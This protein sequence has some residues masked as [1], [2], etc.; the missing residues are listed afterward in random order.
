MPD[1]LTTTKTLVVIKS[2]LR[3]D[4]ALTEQAEAAGW[5]LQLFNN[6]E[7]AD[8]FLRAEEQLGEINLALF[9]TPAEVDAAVSLLKERVIPN[10]ARFHRILVAAQLAQGNFAPLE[11]TVG[12][13]EAASERGTTST[14]T[15]GP[16]HL[17]R[18]IAAVKE[19]LT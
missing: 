10:R 7:E 5:T 1:T 16:M 3:Y 19:M 12:T 13:V 2:D 18:F 17:N 15:Y 8:R 4:S 14:V 6:A 11:A 9:V